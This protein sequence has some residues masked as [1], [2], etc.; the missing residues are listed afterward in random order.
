MRRIKTIDAE[1][2]GEVVRLII[3]GAPSVPGRTMWEKQTWFRK[4]GE[5]LR[6]LLMLE[7]RGH[8]GMHGALLTEPVSAHADAGVVSMHAAGYPVVSGEGAVAAAT[9]ALE[10]RLIEGVADELI[11]DTLAGPLHLRPCYASSA[12]V[13]PAPV[14]PL[15]P[16]APRIA[17]VRLTAVPSFVHAGGLEVHVAGRLVR[18]DV[19][20]GGEFYAVADSEAT[21][22]PVEVANESSLIRMGLEVGRAVESAITVVHPT[23]AWMKGIRGTI[24]TG[25]P[26]GDADLR[27]ATVL[28]GGILR[29]SP[30]IT[31]TAALLTI[32]DAMGLVGVGH[33]FA[34]EGVLGTILRAEIVRRSEADGRTI[35]LSEVEATATTTAFCEFV[36]G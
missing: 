7:P 35:V 30:G 10:N 22:I 2:A 34:H 16:V 6:R 13:A 26:R 19:A 1:V 23:F 32:L 9:L 33:Q 24:F 25:A 28:H 29:R 18:V 36:I 15:A 31:G 3:S 8:S 14:A 21:G 4:N 27:S 17:S 20:Y 5:D 12:P 11:L